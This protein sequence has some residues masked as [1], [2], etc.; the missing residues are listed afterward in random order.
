MGFQCGGEP[1]VHFPFIG[2]L[3]QLLESFHREHYS[4][5]FPVL[6]QY[7]RLVGLLEFFQMGSGVAGKIR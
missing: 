3:G 5:G 1:D 4:R 6:G 2:Q 7:P